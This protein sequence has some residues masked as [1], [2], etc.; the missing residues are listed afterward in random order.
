MPFPRVSHLPPFPL[1]HG[2]Y[3][4]SS[5]HPPRFL[6]VRDSPHNPSVPS[7]LQPLPAPLLS[8]RASHRLILT[9]SFL[10]RFHALPSRLKTEAL[11]AAAGPVYR[12]FYLFSVPL[13]VSHLRRVYSYVSRLL[14]FLLTCFATRQPLPSSASATPCLPSE[15]QPHLLPR[16]FLCVSHPRHFPTSP[17]SASF[18]VSGRQP[19]RG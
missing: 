7:F 19:P 8:H 5:A 11:G 4:I 6:P 3:P 9:S 2:H 13:H 18:L 17:S 10:L 15:R 1:R 14:R 16:V 12:P